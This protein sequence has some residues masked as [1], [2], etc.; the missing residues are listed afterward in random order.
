MIEVIQSQTQT[1]KKN[2]K[3]EQSSQI[4]HQMYQ[5]THNGNP[6]REK[7]TE[8]NFFEEIV[9]KSILNLMKTL[10]HISKNKLQVG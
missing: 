1:E 3:N 4:R 6:R 9:A 2:E 7:R 10:I 5:H 8:K